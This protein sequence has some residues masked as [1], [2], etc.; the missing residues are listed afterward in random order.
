MI[1]NGL[2]TTPTYI[3]TS[4]VMAATHRPFQK[5]CCV[6]STVERP[7]LLLAAAGAVILTYDLETRKLLNHGPPFDEAA[8]EDE[9]SIDGAEPAKRRKLNHSTLSQ[10]T[11]EDSVE[12]VAERKKGERRKPKVEESKLPNV[13]HLVATSNGQNI[14]A[15]SAEDKCIIV[16]SLTSVCRLIVE[17]RR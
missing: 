14:V 3:S 13:S 7:S 16:F 12:I 4:F 10:E 2:S 15:I 1:R 9:D 11:S 6:P 17:S 5:L 8:S